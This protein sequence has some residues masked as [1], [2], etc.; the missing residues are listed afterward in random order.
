MLLN[1]IIKVLDNTDTRWKQKEQP[2]SAKLAGVSN[3]N[4]NCLGAKL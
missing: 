3:P 1:W 4:N 2:K